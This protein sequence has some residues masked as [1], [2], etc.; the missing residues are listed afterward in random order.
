MKKLFL[1]L[2]LIITSTLISCGDVSKDSTLKDKELTNN[3]KTNFEINSMATDNQ[4]LNPIASIKGLNLDSNSITSS[5]IVSNKEF[6]LLA[7]RF[8]N[9][10]LY[11]IPKDSLKSNYDFKKINASSLTANSLALIDD[12]I[13]FSNGSDN[14][15]IYSFNLSNF[16]NH[17]VDTKKLNNSNSN[18]FIS[19][20]KGVYY[21]NQSDQNKLYRINADASENIAIIQDSCGQYSPFDSWVLYENASDKFKLYA[22]NLETNSSMKLTDFSIESFAV[23]NNIAYVSNS[24]DNNHIYRIDLSTLETKKLFDVSA[25]NLIALENNLIFQ[26]TN[27]F[28]ELFKL[29]LTSENL[30]L[31][32]LNIGSPSEY[33][34]NDDKIF[35]IYPNNPESYIMKSIKDITSS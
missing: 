34:L 16:N 18:N 31:T 4:Y 24:A 13:L 15:S 25:T 23:A 30:S 22:M 1:T 11:K 19:S 2:T 6:Y 26:N 27:S 14:G 5:Y 35:F 7:N 17:E 12:T 20:S 8:Y 33:F 32:N 3:K 29:N 28:N 9:N 10:K 21:I